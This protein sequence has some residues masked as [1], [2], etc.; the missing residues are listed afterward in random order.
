MIVR[1]PSPFPRLAGVTIIFLA[2]GERD[3]VVGV[4]MPGGVAPCGE[5]V[6]V[7][8]SF[9]LPGYMP[10]RKGGRPGLARVIL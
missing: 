2:A 7:A 10:G 1:R 6:Q 8:F 5:H 3:R 4:Q 9:I